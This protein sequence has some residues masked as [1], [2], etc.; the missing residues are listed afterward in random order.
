M[1][2]RDIGKRAEEVISIVKE[3]K[4]SEGL[5]EED[6]KRK[7]IEPFFEAFGWDFS[8]YGEIM[9]TME[10][11]LSTKSQKDKA[12]YIFKLRDASIFI[13]EAKSLNAD[14]TEKDRDQ[15]RRYMLLDGCKFGA[16][17]NGQIYEFLKKKEREIESFYKINVLAL[18]EEVE[19][20]VKKL[21][22]LCRDTWEL[23]LELGPAEFEKTIDILA[24]E[25]RMRS[26]MVAA[27]PLKSSPSESSS[28]D[29]GKAPRGAA[30]SQKTFQDAVLKILQKENGLTGSEIIQRIEAVFKNNLNSWDLGELPTGGVRWKNRVWFGLQ[31]LKNSDKLKLEGHKYYVIQ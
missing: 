16:I 27:V 31:Y 9:V 18:E 24:S 30:T 7:I 29:S 11:N 21:I 28:Q 17:T 23:W 2:A 10:S 22:W 26:K 12:D 25:A 3:L 8:L 6:T 13:L 4:D 14:L 19:E 15:L 20:V 5:S 1:I